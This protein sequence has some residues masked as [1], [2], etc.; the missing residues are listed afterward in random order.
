MPEDQDLTWD[1]MDDGAISISVPKLD[2]YS[3]VV[4]E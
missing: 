3:I 2:I 4:I 1:T